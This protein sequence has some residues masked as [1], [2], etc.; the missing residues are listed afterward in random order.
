MKRSPQA[1]FTLVE[2]IVAVGLFGVVMLVSV[3]AL[4]ALVDANRKAQALQSV[5]NN[6]NIAVDGMSRAIREG[7]N[8]RCN[9][10]VAPPTG[11]DCI[12]GDDLLYFESHDGLAS[13]PNDDWVYEF[14]NGRI[15]K[16]TNGSSNPS[17]QVAITAAEVTI[18]SVQF[19]VFG[20]SRSDIVQPKVMMVIKGTAGTTKANVKTTFHV[21]TTAVQRVLDI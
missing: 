9:V 3:T 14:R 17:G 1:G 18:E 16:S 10:A 2:M 11:A 6:L 19:Y 15:Y 13:N 20:S 12:L 21:Q 7:S 8:Y 4:V 5:I